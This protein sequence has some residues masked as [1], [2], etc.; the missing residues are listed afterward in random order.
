LSK[1]AKA[2]KALIAPSVF[3]Q[4]NYGNQLSRS[5]MMVLLG[6]VSYRRLPIM[7]VRPDAG[8][9]RGHRMVMMNMVV[10]MH[11]GFFFASSLRKREAR[12]KNETYGS[13]NYLST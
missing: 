10:T 1:R 5:K 12:P 7:W 11:C 9:T 13:D 4:V 8:F 3:S 2:R 6:M